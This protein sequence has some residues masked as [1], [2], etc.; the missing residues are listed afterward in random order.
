[1]KIISWNLN[2]IRA[3]FRKNE[4][5]N[6]FEKFPAEI[7]LFQEIK[8]DA[9]AFSIF[10]ENFPQFFCAA[11]CAAK[12][13]YAGSAIF[14]DE[15]FAAKKNLKFVK[16]L[17]NLADDEGRV[18]RVEFDDFA[19]F[20]VYFPNGGKSPAAWKFKLKFYE[21]FLAEISA[22]RKTG[23]KVIFGGDVNCAA[24]K[25]DLAR[26]REND[27]KIGFH[28]A[29]RAALAKFKSENFVDFFR[30]KF[31]RQI[32]YSWWD[33]KTRARERNVGWRL[34]YFF[35]D[36]IFLPRIKKIEYL[37]SQFGSDHCPVFLE[38]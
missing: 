20:S 10:A 36:E 15:K 28:P 31:P 35:G 25:I 24:T 38:I 32:S 37:N 8:I 21:K 27:G 29:E 18:L 14:V 13:G 1:M 17:Q 22:L 23:K 9:A 2:G 12:K 34:D 3:V 26:P 30:E 6:L 19:I 4:L 16:N 33:L 11:N 7:Y 5:Q